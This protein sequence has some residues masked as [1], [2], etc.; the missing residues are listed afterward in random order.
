[1]SDWIA[2]A[3]VG[4]IRAGECKIID[5]DDVMVA[6]YCLDGEYYAIEDVCTHDGGELSS[7]WVEGD[8][9]VC[10][11]HGAM[12]CIR[13]G[14]VKQGPAFEPTASFPLRIKGELIEIKDDRFD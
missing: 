10:P 8:C 13:T 4:E 7:G 6:V 2:V 9:A 3:K 11:R 12:F 14:E 5:L 1:M